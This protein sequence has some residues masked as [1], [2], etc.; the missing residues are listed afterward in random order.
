MLLGA[1]WVRTQST[2]QSARSRF[3]SASLYSSAPGSSS[4]RQDTPLYPE[5][6]PQPGPRNYCNHKTRRFTT[7]SADGRRLRSC[8]PGPVRWCPWKIQKKLSS[9]QKE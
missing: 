9:K 4:G 5:Y 1:Q 2:V 6:G 7:S 8:A 3:A